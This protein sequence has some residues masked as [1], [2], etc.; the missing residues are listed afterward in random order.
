MRS[1]EDV[2]ASID[3]S[4]AYYTDR[5]A[6]WE[7]VKRETRKTGEDFAKFSRNFSGVQY[8]SE[9]YDGLKKVYVTVKQ[10]G[11]YT[12]D[13][14]T[15]PADVSAAFAAIE[16]LIARYKIWRDECEKQKT[17]AEKAASLVLDTIDKL[18]ADL[19]TLGADRSTKYIL[20]DLVKDEGCYRICK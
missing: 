1:I 19:K 12:E 6:A 11:G 10:S 8:V 15:V 3:N 20:A 9:Q 18:A 14:V 13:W 17:I 5:I 2:I 7:N 16:G 4:I